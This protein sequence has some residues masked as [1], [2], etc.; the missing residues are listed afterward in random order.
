MTQ[1]EQQQF[2]WTKRLVPEDVE[3]MMKKWLGCCA[4]GTPW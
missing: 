3:P 4:T 1:E 2:G